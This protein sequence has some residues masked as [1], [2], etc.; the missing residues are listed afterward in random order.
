MLREPEYPWM[1]E[2]PPRGV[3]K[4]LLNHDYAAMEFRMM[5]KMQYSQELHDQKTALNHLT[6]PV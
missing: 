4:N 1:T 3:E 6:R 5:S 2:I